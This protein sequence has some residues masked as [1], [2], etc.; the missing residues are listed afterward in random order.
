MSNI[1]ICCLGK[2]GFYYS[3]TD[4]LYS[5]TNTGMHSSSLW[6]SFLAIIQQ[7]RALERAFV[8]LNG[9]SMH[10]H[11][12][13]KY[14]SEVETPLYSVHFRWCPHYRV[15]YIHQILQSIGMSICWHTNYG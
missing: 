13:Q 7:G 4:I 6:L 5:R 11:A 3:G 2:E 15:L 10:C 8:M 12:Y 14:T 1:L 9:M